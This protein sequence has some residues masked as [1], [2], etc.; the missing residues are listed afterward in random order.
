MFLSIKNFCLQTVFYWQ[1]ICFDVLF[2]AVKLDLLSN[3]LAYISQIKINPGQILLV[4][5]SQSSLS[6]DVYE[7]RVI[8]VAL[9]SICS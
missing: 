5:G 9:E 1:H 2:V 3:I 7:K 6:Y 8:H 4:Y